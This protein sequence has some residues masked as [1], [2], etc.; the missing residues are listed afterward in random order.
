MLVVVLLS[1]CRPS[2]F[3]YYPNRVLYADPHH[4][5]VDY[6][7]L[8]I[9]SLNGKILSAILFQTEKEE[10]LGTVVHFHGNFG[11]VSNHF[12]QSQFLM[13]HGFDVIVFDYQGF[14][15]SQGKSNPRRT[16]EDGT[17]VVR[18]ARDHSRNAQ[19]NVYVFGQS[20]GAAVGIVVTAQEAFVRAAVFEAPFTS[21][22]TMAF[23]VTGKTWILW[24]LYPIYPWFVG[25][26]Y[27]PIRYIAKI[28]PRPI[29]LIHG[30]ADEI[31]PFKMSLKLF[32]Q[33][34]DPK[35]FWEVKGAKHLHIKRN[36]GKKYE[37]KL[38]QF[39]SQVTNP[40]KKD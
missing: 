39:F 19:K 37:E 12:M 8:E 13:N 30:T 35:E 33:A 24:P 40:Q 7:L 18:Y 16:V 9:P 21:Y 5:G 32:A 36:E 2:T 10:S 20:L 22:R 34:K 26:R 28:S 27:D 14:G 38:A 3:F 15:G 29:L 17:A 25:T 11:N 4:N 6:S 1:G 31:V 23:H